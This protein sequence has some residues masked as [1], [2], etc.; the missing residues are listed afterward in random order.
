LVIDGRT[1][2]YPPIR[3]VHVRAALT[4]RLNGP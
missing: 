1:I 2:L 3:L 4:G